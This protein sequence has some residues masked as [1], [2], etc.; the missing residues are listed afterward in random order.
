MC[1]YAIMSALT[2]DRVDG[3]H[4]SVCH[5]CPQVAILCNYTC[6]SLMAQVIYL[7]I[8]IIN[9]YYY[10]TVVIPISLIYV[11]YELISSLTTSMTP[12]CYCVCAL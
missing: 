8:L 6:V 10:H 12:L 2:F 1:T 7:L 11:L 4:E 9:M 3:C 5:H